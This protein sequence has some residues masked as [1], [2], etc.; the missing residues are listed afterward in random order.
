M[1]DGISDEVS[2]KVAKS[3]PS[4]KLTLASLRSFATLREII[5]LN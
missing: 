1:A 2:R 5:F 3:T 4:R